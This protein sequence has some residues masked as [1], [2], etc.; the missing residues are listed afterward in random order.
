PRGDTVAEA[1]YFATKLRESGLDVSALVV[2]RMHPSFGTGSAEAARAAVSAGG[3]LAPYWAN[4]ADFR[5]IASR[6]RAQ[7]AG[8]VEGVDGATVIHVPFLSTDV[9]DL[10]G[11][12][13]VGR[14][15]LAD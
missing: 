2:N 8:L 1:S 4:L 13:E 3:P 9:H 11:L 10:D 5:E 6:E 7:L 12:A 15:L 14:Y